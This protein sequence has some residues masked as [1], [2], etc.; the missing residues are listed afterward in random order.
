MTYRE[1][2]LTLHND[3]TPDEAQQMYQGYLKEWWGSEVRAEFEAKKTDELMRRQ[4]DPR[5]LQ[6][7]VDRRNELAATEARSFAADWEGSKLDPAA[8]GFNQGDLQGSAPGPWPPVGS[9][10]NGKA[11]E[12]SARPHVPAV[13]WTDSRLAVDLDLSRRLMV[14]LDEEKGMA[15][16]NPL[17]SASQQQEEGE[18][19]QGEAGAGNGA[20]DGEAAEGEGADGKPKRPCLPEDPAARLDLQLAYLWRVHGVDYYGGR[21]YGG[22]DDPTRVGARRTLRCPK[23]ETKG[24]DG[25]D[26]EEGEK[27]AGADKEAGEKASEGEPAGDAA[28]KQ[29]LEEVQ[30]QVDE[31]WKP[32][33]EMEDLMEAPLQKKKVAT[34]L[35]EFVESQ[36]TRIDDNKWGSKLSQKLFVGKGYVVKHIRVKHAHVVDAER[37]RVLDLIYY[38]N[39]QRFREEEAARRREHAERLAA[40]EREAALEQAAGEGE[41][42]G[43][44]GEAAFAMGM[45]RGRGAALMPGAAPMVMGPLDAGPMLPLMG[46]GPMGQ[47]LVPAPGAGPLG[48]FIMA[49]APPMGPLMDPMAAAAI[50][51]Q[52]PPPPGRGGPGRGGR[53][54]GGRGGGM[55]MMPGMMPGRGA[56]MMGRGMGPGGRMGPGGFMMQP[57]PPPGGKFATVRGMREYHDLDAP[58]NNR[59]VLDYG[60]L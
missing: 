20:A 47:V 42:E 60:D 1:F 7:L 29:Q 31:I 50:A 2:M 24:K 38:D 27:E 59:S 19:Q 43:M 30:Q 28:S 14:K 10:T 22:P 32:R 8:E 34:S 13:S 9:D 41:F 16:L 56:G 44:E 6:K 57:P 5:E 4:F 18:G 58:Q 36:I 15:Q 45:G 52:V 55:G 49:P 35:D 40:Q 33:L 51:P 39:F 3:V 26:G 54:G 46:A 11:A 17:T 12:E 21:E 25:E 37:E 53:G 48:P 23:P